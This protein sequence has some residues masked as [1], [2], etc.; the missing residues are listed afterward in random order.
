MHDASRD[1]SRVMLHFDSCAIANDRGLTSNID[2]F[3]SLL[4]AHHDGLILGSN[5]TT[6]HQPQTAPAAALPAVNWCTRQRDYSHMLSAVTQNSTRRHHSLLSLTSASPPTMTSAAAAATFAPIFD[7]AKSAS[8]GVTS[9][10]AFLGGGMGLSGLAGR[11]TVGGLS[12]LSMAESARRND[13]QGAARPI[14][15]VRSKSLG[16][17]R[18][19]LGPTRKSE[20]S[21]K[22]PHSLARSVARSLTRWVFLGRRAGDLL[23]QVAHSA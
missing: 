4:H 22:V 16:D 6:P 2:T 14:K 12:P 13:Q 19:S 11:R 3:D 23:Q 8:F 1:A 9:P 10:S 21:A 7:N 20:R 15:V 18:K 5:A 17:E